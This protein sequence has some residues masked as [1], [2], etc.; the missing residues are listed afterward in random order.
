MLQTGTALNKKNRA[1]ASL[2]KVE[3]RDT[4]SL[5]EDETSDPFVFSCEWA[6]TTG[7]IHLGCCCANRT[8]EGLKVLW[9]ILQERLSLECTHEKEAQASTGVQRSGWNI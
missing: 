8:V 4:I 2:Q 3:I 7:N 1:V 9:V 6:L 5:T